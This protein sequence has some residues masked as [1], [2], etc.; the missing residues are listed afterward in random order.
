MQ[1]GLTNACKHS[2]SEMI[3]IKIE[4][5][6]DRLKIEIR[7]WGIGFN[8]KAARKNRFG[9]DGIRERARLLGGRCSIRSARGRGTSIGVELPVVERGED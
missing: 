5:K 2:Q 1:E 8:V 7:D 4:Q 6:G 9:I 3:V